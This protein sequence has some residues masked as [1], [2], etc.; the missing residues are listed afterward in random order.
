MFENYLKNYNCFRIVT[1]HKEI[2]IFAQRLDF[3]DLIYTF[4]DKMK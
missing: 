4:L 3:F 2:Q 1:E